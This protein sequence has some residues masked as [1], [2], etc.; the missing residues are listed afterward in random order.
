MKSLGTS[1]KTEIPSNDNYGELAEMIDEYYQLSL[2]G[3]S[4]NDFIS[5]RIKDPQ[6]E[7]PNCLNHKS[8]DIYSKNDNEMQTIF[9]LMLNRIK[10]SNENLGNFY[11]SLKKFYENYWLNQT[12]S[13]N[14]PFIFSNMD[15]TANNFKNNFL[16][17]KTLF[18]DNRY[19]FRREIE[20]FFLDGNF[21][22]SK[23]L[24]VFID[25]LIFTFNDFDYISKLIHEF[26]VYIETNYDIAYL[27]LNINPV[28]KNK[29]I[30]K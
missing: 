6:N 10:E 28:K 18:N 26:L 23:Q 12:P 25:S 21:S 22:Q 15:K 13:I 7:F 30:T 29:N 3:G 8:F 27:S 9:E 20:R 5:K 16:S 11:E 1:N 19:R 24:K 14:N 4:E 17:Y 2:I